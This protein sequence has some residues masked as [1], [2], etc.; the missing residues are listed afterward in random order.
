MAKYI[1]VHCDNDTVDIET[2]SDI[3][4]QVESLAKNGV[5]NHSGSKFHPPKN[6]VFIEVLDK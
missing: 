2:A 4:K 6:I 3:K 1:R 5:W